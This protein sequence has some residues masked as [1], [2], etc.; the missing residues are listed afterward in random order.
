MEKIY[1]TNSILIKHLPIILSFKGFPGFLY[2]V[3][4][5]IF[6]ALTF[7][8]LEKIYFNQNQKIKI[9]FNIKTV[10]KA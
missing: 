3:I 7:E 10:E 9:T 2:G 8:D 6:F 4:F 1:K 5:T